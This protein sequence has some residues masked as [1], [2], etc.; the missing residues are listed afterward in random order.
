MTNINAVPIDIAIQIDTLHPPILSCACFT[1]TSPH[2]S[3][4]SALCGHDL[5]KIVINFFVKEEKDLLLLM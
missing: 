3:H 5:H 2:I 4:Q 1:T